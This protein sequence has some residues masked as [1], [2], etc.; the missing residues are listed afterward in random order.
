MYYV[1]GKWTNLIRHT[2]MNYSQ[3]PRMKL[4]H[5]RSIYIN[6]LQGYLHF[7]EKK[8]VNFNV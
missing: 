6:S 3:S 7:K 8:T 5:N 2:M 1:F 4:E